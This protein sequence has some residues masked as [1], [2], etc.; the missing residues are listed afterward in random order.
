MKA[1][2]FTATARPAQSQSFYSQLPG[3]RFV[4]D[5]PYALVF[6]VEG[7]ELRIQKVDALQP[8]PYT[9]LG[10]QVDDINEQVRALSEL[11]VV[12]EKFDFLEQDQLAIWSSPDGARVAWFKDPDGNTLSLTQQP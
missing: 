2:L 7:T 3:F 11:G 6:E 1:I 9:T 10:F 8:A 12:F 5:S 4:T